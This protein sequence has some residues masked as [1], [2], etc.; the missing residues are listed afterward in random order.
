MSA[1]AHNRSV[2]SLHYTHPWYELHTSHALS[3]SL[4]LF[5]AHSHIQPIQD[6]YTCSQRALNVQHPTRFTCSRHQAGCPSPHLAVAINQYVLTTQFWHNPL[7]LSSTCCLA[8][9]RPILVPELSHDPF[10]VP[11]WQLLTCWRPECS[12]VLLRDLRN[13]L[14]HT[15]VRTFDTVQVASGESRHYT[16][17]STRHAPH[18]RIQ[19]G[20]QFSATGHACKAGEESRH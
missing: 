20:W 13:P 14:T 17:P 18:C 15:P 2:C 9:N 12:R 7:M 16:I 1:V 8:S 5:L 6:A 19:K 11:K 3:H 4:P 10:P